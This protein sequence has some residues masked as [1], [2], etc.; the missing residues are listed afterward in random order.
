MIF[1]QYLKIYQL[2]NNYSAEIFKLLIKFL[3]FEGESI[4]KNQLEIY[5]LIF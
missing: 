3:E 1:L 5:K 2:T 4:G